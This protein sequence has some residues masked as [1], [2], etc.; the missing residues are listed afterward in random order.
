[1]YKDGHTTH[2]MAC[3]SLQGR[4]AIETSHY[5]STWKLTTYNVLYG[6]V[7]EFVLYLPVAL[8]AELQVHFFSCLGNFLIWVDTNSWTTPCG[9]NEWI[10]RKI[11]EP[12]VRG[13][14]SLR[15]SED[16]PWRD[17]QPNRCLR[18]RFDSR[19]DQPSLSQISTSN[20]N[21]SIHH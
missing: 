7:Q 6:V 20:E 21:V 1:M 11:H 13:K 18:C 9:E 15:Y 5:E 16:S 12:N 19:G 3:L 17:R 2:Y 10:F 14:K 8:Y 4:M